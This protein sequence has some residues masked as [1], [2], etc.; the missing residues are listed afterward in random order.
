MSRRP[1]PKAATE[2]APRALDPG[3]HK[4]VTLAPPSP[5]PR[6]SA[7]FSDQDHDTGGTGGPA[8]EP[9]QGAGEARLCANRVDGECSFLRP[10]QEELLEMARCATVKYDYPSGL[11]GS[12][13][14]MPFPPAAADAVG[15]GE[16]EQELIAR[17][18]DEARAELRAQLAAILLEFGVSSQDMEDMSLQQMRAAAVTRQSLD[19][20]QAARRSIARERAGLERAPAPRT[21]TEKFEHLTATM[22]DVYERTLAK[23]LGPDRAA[24]LRAA[25]DGWSSRSVAGG[26]C[27]TEG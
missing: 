12:A 10:S 13:P 15:L 8:I 2:K 25:G 26:Q 6:P 21:P 19:D 24:E 27:D 23:F 3:S 14:I 5:F 20:V 22:G 1:P 16:G 11:L 7:V 17:A 18:T 9:S 4:T